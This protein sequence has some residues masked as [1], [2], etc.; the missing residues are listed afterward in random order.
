[1][2]K[3]ILKISLCCTILVVLLA[4]CG[5]SKLTGRWQEVP[6]E[7]WAFSEIEFFSDGTYDSD[8]AN[9]CGNYSVEGNRLRISGIMVS[10]ETFSFKVEDGILYL[11]NSNGAIYQYKKVD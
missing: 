1:M 7:G 10:D 8:Y 5:K 11:E 2:N 4:G 9:Y 6:N 3:R